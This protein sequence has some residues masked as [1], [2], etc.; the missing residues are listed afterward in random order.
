M[1]SL[2]E[3]KR[4]SGKSGSG[5]GSGSSSGKYASVKPKL[6]TGKHAGNV[7]PKPVQPK[8]EPFARVSRHELAALITKQTAADE[9]V[10]RLV[11][12]ASAMGGAHVSLIGAAVDDPTAA[13]NYVRP[14]YLLLD[15]RSPEE[16]TACHIATAV[17]YPAVLLRRDQFPKVLYDFVSA[18]PQATDC[19]HS[20]IS[21]VWCARS[22]IDDDRVLYVPRVSCASEKSI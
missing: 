2:S 14:P 18:G 10:L 3:S 11:S 20:R 16:F 15:I 8:N 22:D 17:N 5:G 21:Y 4:S 1:S 9:S 7:P 6:D 13:A 19:A 12:S